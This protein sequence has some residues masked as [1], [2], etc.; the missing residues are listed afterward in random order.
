LTDT[1]EFLYKTTNYYVPSSDRGIKWNDENI[2]IEWPVAGL[3][4]TL[5]DKDRVQPEFDEAEYF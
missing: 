2:A 3:V 1:A 5:S 4:I